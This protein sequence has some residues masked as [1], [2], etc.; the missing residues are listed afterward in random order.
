MLL[1]CRARSRFLLH[2]VVNGLLVPHLGRSWG[3]LPRG[4]LP[5]R[6][7][8]LAGSGRM[9]LAAL[10]GEGLFGGRGGGCEWSD[11]VEWESL[12]GENQESSP[13]QEALDFVVVCKYR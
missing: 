6:W 10:A 8:L 4:F 5:I 11:I 9:V 12:S 2:R 13:H 1:C 3:G 7:E